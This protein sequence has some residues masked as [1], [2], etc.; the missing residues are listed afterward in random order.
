MTSTADAMNLLD[1]L[2]LAQRNVHQELYPHVMSWLKLLVARGFISEETAEQ[3]FYYTGHDD[4]SI[5]YVYDDEQDGEGIPWYG[6]KIWVPFDFIENP[7]PY[8]E[9]LARYQ[10][11]QKEWKQRQ[12]ANKDNQRREE[13][14]GEIAALT[15]Q[16]EL[17]EKRMGDK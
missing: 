13:L 5:T 10:A 4:D 16:L 9:R 2:N 1:A 7:A 17:L 15:L 3:H 6:S 11:Q 14:Q 8:F 12:T